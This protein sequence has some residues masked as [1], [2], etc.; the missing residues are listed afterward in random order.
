[1]NEEIRFY[2]KVRL[3]DGSYTNGKIDYNHH[4]ELLGILPSFTRGT[5]VLDIAAN[6]GFWSFW[7][8]DAGAKDV[9]AIDV[10]S[11]ENYDW[12]YD[13]YSDMILPN[14][15]SS[16]HASQWT[17][18][19]AGFWYLHKI[20]NS[21]VKREKLSVYGLKPEKHGVFDL[22]FM[23]GLLYHLRHPLL[24]LDTVRRVCSGVLILETHVVNSFKNI[25]AS[26][27]YW[28]DVFQ[29]HTNWTGPTESS[30]VAWAKSAGF[31]H[32]FSRIMNPKS[33]YTRGIFVCCIND[34]WYD[35]FAKNKDLIYYNEKRLQEIKNKTKNLLKNNENQ[36]EGDAKIAEI[37]FKHGQELLNLGEGQKAIVTLS[38]AL[39]FNE[40]IPLYHVWIARAYKECKEILSA[41]SSLEKALE[42]NPGSTELHM[43]ANTFVSL[44]CLERAVDVFEMALVLAPNDAKLQSNY[45]RVLKKVGQCE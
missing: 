4:P 37:Y 23:Y 12:G 5:R 22:I 20:Y 32:I 38:K 39:H 36:E 10:D 34:D 30:I 3:P 41:L 1:M 7:A 13:G 31:P 6:D 45:S 44:N 9:L 8:E 27:F 25:P 29:S 42:L 15:D 19:G 16:T 40:N 11:F 28:D 17:N 43:I 14:L 21:R 33:A 2:M 26:L 24:A 18:S 35:K